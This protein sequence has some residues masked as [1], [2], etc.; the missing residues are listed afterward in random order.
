MTLTFIS[1]GHA[2]AVSPALGDS[3]DEFIIPTGSEEIIIPEGQ[4]G[5]GDGGGLAIPMDD[6]MMPMQAITINIPLDILSDFN[7]Q[8][9]SNAF[10]DATCAGRTGKY[11]L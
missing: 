7:H 2:K 3:S 9:K 8:I 11:G 6:S 10:F 4:L 1:S 5:V